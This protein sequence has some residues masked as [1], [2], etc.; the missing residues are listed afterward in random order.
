M[1]NDMV[2]FCSKDIDQ[3][4]CSHIYR[5]QRQLCRHPQPKG[6]GVCGGSGVCVCVGQWC[7]CGGN[8]VCDGMDTKEVVGRT[9][10]AFCYL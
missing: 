9:I 5:A 3:K 8:G 7:V 1:A 4:L 6:S 2:P 10:Q